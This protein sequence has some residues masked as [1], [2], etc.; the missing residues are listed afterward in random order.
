M[1]TTLAYARAHT[2]THTRAHTHSYV[3]IFGTAESGW[4]LP[5]PPTAV[6]TVPVVFNSIVYYGQWNKWWGTPLDRAGLNLT[7]KHVSNGTWEI[8]SP[9]PSF[10]F[11]DGFVQAQ[12]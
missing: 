11:T 7:L 8:T 2:H 10:T 1:L 4:R 6:M 5:I 12:V 3:H 9:D